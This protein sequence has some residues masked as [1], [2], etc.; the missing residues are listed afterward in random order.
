MRK[1]L[2]PFL[3]VEKPSKSVA[4]NQTA[5]EPLKEPVKQLIL[6]EIDQDYLNK[7]SKSS[8]S[9]WLGAKLYL[10][11]VGSPTAKSSTASDETSSAKEDSAIGEVIHMSNNGMIGIAIVQLSSL[12]E[13]TVSTFV[14]K[15]K[16][17]ES[18]DINANQSNQS[19]S[20]MYIST[21]RPDWFHGLDR[22]TNV[23]TE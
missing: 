22:N 2:V 4:P 18:A 8:D 10:E 17:T 6:N 16:S 7:A 3:V 14:V 1:R 11:Q 13:S 21:F 23:R 19:S 20:A 5:F 9:I 12:Y 15:P